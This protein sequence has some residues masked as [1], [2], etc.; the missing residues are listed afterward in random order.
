MLD[1]KLPVFPIEFHSYH[2]LNKPVSHKHLA[3][4]PN[5]K[6]K[7]P[8]DLCSD[9][10]TVV[11]LK[12]EFHLL[13]LVHRVSCCRTPKFLESVWKLQFPSSHTLKP[14]SGCWWIISGSP[15][16]CLPVILEY[17]QDKSNTSLPIPKAQMQGKE[18]NAKQK[19]RFLVLYHL[20]FL[21]VCNRL[22]QDFT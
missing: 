11:H 15:M 21:C 1:I 18:K 9:Q 10:P 19:S 6:R 2:F 16:Q 4:L 12:A 17:G 14:L 13:R 20:T 22:N 5:T 8:L 3:D 7:S